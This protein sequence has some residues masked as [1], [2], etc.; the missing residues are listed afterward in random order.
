MPAGDRR[1]DVADSWHVEEVEVHLQQDGQVLGS[2]TIPDF[3]MRWPIAYDRFNLR[4]HWF[5]P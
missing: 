5:L 4:L 3:S 2:Q 1:A